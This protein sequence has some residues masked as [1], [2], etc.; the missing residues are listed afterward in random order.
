MCSWISHEVFVSLNRGRLL[1][2][3]VERR[4]AANLVNMIAGLSRRSSWKMIVGDAASVYHE[5]LTTLR[6]NEVSGWVATCS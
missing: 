1:A 6:T 2:G 4:H 3:V 5:L